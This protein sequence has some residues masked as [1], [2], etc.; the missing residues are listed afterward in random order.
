[1]GRRLGTDA[2]VPEHA[3]VANAVGAVVGRVAL[4]VEGTVTS[5]APGVFIAHLPDGPRRFA[6]QGEALSALSDALD[7]EATARAQAAGAAEVEL[8]RTSD[9]REAEVEGSPMFVEARLRVTAQGRARLA[10]Q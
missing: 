9:R 5:P 4:A 2:K 10:T 1:M 8:H 3:E 6:D 7:A